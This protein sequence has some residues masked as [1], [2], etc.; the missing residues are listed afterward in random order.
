VPTAKPSG[1]T[2]PRLAP[3]R[4]SLESVNRTGLMITTTDALGVLRSIDPDGP[5]AERQLATFEVVPG[6]ANRDCISLRTDDGRYVR[7]A[8]GRVQ[9]GRDEG[10][11]LYRADATFCVRAGS[12][13]GS[14]A[15]QSFNYPSYYLRHRGNE[16]WVDQTDGSK[17]FAA[18][19][20]FLRR[21][22]LSP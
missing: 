18:D 16:L 1:T 13:P 4:L 10:T 6:L 15:L 17:A 7:H 11:N 14:V 3:G 19:S 2:A 21:A 5:P 12:A 22:P 20:S 8:S 9:V